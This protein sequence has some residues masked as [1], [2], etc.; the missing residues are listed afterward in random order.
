MV[1][2]LHSSL[3]SEIAESLGEKTRACLAR[4]HAHEPEMILDPTIHA[5]TKLGAVVVLLYEDAG[6]LRVLLTT[7]AKTMRTYPGETALPGGKMDAGETSFAQT[8]VRAR[9]SSR[10]SS[11]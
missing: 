5:H 1:S 7:R 2:Y 8:A 9:A 6:A 3:P 10:G 11:C 4:L